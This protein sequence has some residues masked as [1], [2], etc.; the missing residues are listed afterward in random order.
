MSI[1]ASIARVLRRR[2]LATA[3]IIAASF[4]RS[5]LL[6][7]HGK[8][9]LRLV[10][11]EQLVA[12][13]SALGPP[14]DLAESPSVELPREA[15]VLRG[16]RFRLGQHPA[17]RFGEV[18]GKDRLGEEIGA[19]YDE[20][21]SMG[22]PRDDLTHGR[23]CEETQ[24]T[25][26]EDLSLR[27]CRLLGRLRLGLARFVG[28]VAYPPVIILAVLLRLGVLVLPRSALALLRQGALALPGWRGRRSDRVAHH[29]AGRLVAGPKSPARGRR[30]QGRR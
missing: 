24:E 28:G 21:S 7:L 9:K 2:A 3:Q 15:G 10:P 19:E 13:C 20:G 17:L 27:L 6:A 5:A 14:V 25:L 26:G 11:P 16:G 12:E 18:G 29:D 22:E 4:L 8:A 23:V 1:G 30:S